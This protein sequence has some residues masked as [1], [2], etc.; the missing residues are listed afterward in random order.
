MTL[1]RTLVA[2]PPWPFGDKLPGPSRGAEK[3]YS[4][5]SIEG[6]CRYLD[7]W[8]PHGRICGLPDECSEWPT[9]KSLL[10]PDCRLFLWRVSSM[11]AEALETMKAWGF[12][13]PK[14]ELVWVK[15]TSKGFVDPFR[16]VSFDFRDYDPPVKLPG[17][18]VHFGMGRTTRAAHETCLVGQ[19]GKPEV[20]D[21][22]VR[23]VFAAPYA[24]HSVKPDAFYEL[25]EKLSPGPYLE[26]FARRRRPGWTC[27]GDEL[28]PV[29]VATG[30]QGAEEPRAGR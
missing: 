21:N 20:T 14:T 15:L 28:E 27:L 16:Q 5:L 8:S 9:L 26:L 11:Q 1:F 13:A 24:G 4:V 17:A 18:K 7:E 22:A 12:G 23:D 10:A 6:I 29:E 3:N 30:V 19:R 2:D 25:V